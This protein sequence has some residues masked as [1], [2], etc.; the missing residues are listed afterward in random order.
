MEI[1]NQP[2]MSHQNNDTLCLRSCEREEKEN[3][4]RQCS[5]TGK[6]QESRAVRV[7]TRGQLLSTAKLKEKTRRISKSEI[8]L[9][10]DAI[11]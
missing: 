8:N 11:R 1:V 5:H 10:P 4:C 7:T 6:K 9:L 3:T 2:G